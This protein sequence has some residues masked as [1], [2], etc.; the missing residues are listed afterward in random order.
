VN[1]GSLSTRPVSLDGTVDH[2]V[3]PTAISVAPAAPAVL[4]WLR[5][6][7]SPLDLSAPTVGTRA[8][9]RRIAAGA[10]L[11]G[12]G[13]ATHGTAEFAI[14]RAQVFEALVARGFR[15]L[16]LES[17]APEAAAIDD[18][19]TRRLGTAREALTPQ[20]FWLW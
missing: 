14:L 7:A 20:N 11:V 10:R 6:A 16:L 17:N 5:R 12:L 19:E 3:S 1:T 8:L 9:A 13:E 18:Y 15:V 4:T 2:Q